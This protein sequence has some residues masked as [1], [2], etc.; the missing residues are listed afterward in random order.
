MQK[1]ALYCLVVLY[2]IVSGIWAYWKG[3]FW[4]LLTQQSCLHH[5]RCVAHYQPDHFNMN[6]FH[7]G[8][9]TSIGR[10]PHH[11]HTTDWQMAEQCKQVIH[12]SM[13]INC[14]RA[15]R[16]LTHY[17]PH[18][19]LN[20]HVPQPR[21]Q[22]LLYL[23]HSHSCSFVTPRTVCHFCVVGMLCLC[24]VP[25]CKHYCFFSRLMLGQHYMC[26]MPSALGTYSQQL[27]LILTELYT[28]SVVPHVCCP[29]DT[30]LMYIA[31][32]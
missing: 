20:F 23:S 8:V 21:H 4:Y 31:D 17:W 32:V 13:P 19:N 28:Q 7:V 1:Y 16:S 10:T 11:S 14:K 5:L 30:S 26:Y 27:S 24:S 12:L 3:K 15:L 6:S 22:M 18:P 9:A 29:L 2:D 25:A